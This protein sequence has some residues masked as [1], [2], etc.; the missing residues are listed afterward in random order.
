MMQTLPILLGAGRSF[1]CD[2]ASVL[3]YFC[4]LAI[5]HATSKLSYTGGLPYC[6][7]TRIWCQV[8]ERVT[9]C[10]W[11]ALRSENSMALKATLVPYFSAYAAGPVRRRHV[12]ASRPT[13]GCRP[14][15]TQCTSKEPLLALLPKLQHTQHPLSFS[16]LPAFAHR[17]PSHSFWLPD[18]RQL[19]KIAGVAGVHCISVLE[20]AKRC[21]D[22]HCTYTSA[23][24]VPAL[25]RSAGSC[26]GFDGPTGLSATFCGSKEAPLVS[27]A[28]YN[29]LLRS[30]YSIFNSCIAWLHRKTPRY[31]PLPGEC[32]CVHPE[33]ARVGRF[34]AALR[35]KECI[36]RACREQTTGRSWLGF[37]HLGGSV[38]TAH[39]TAQSQ[40]YDVGGERGDIRPR[41]FTRSYWLGR[42][43]ALFSRLFQLYGESGLHLPVAGGPPLC[44]GRS[45]LVLCEFHDCCAHLLPCA[46]SLSKYLVAADIGKG[47]PQHGRKSKGAAED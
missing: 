22:R 17:T 41:A 19:R 7:I 38:K 45:G 39:E 26:Q 32:W 10:H 21:I 20:T 23:S 2:T 6:G 9:G 11:V 1:K 42:R 18:F 28:R 25:P 34:A 44:S 4:S 8:T 47:S 29:M 46:S 3:M 5:V 40:P 13:E 33:G 24:Q 12:A 16:L 15:R 43:D 31:V 36:V 37:S 14:P 30:L 27:T 35:C